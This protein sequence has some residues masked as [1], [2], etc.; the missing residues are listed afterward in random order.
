MV[1]TIWPSLF[2]TRSSSS[3]VSISVTWLSGGGVDD[4]GASSSSPSSGSVTMGACE[5]TGSVTGGIICSLTSGIICSVTNLVKNV[6]A[7]YAA[8]YAFSYLP[9]REFHSRIR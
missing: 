3:I 9:Y 7:F 4:L 2:S 1:W 8:F 5:S 6:S